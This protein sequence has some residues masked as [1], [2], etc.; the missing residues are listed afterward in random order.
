[1]RE[2]L[3]SESEYGADV[4]DYELPGLKVSGGFRVGVNSWGVCRV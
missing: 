3:C 1:M 2:I 4:E